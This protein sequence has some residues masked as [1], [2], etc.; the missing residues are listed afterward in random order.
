MKSSSQISL[1]VGLL[2][3]LGAVPLF[4]GGQPLFAGAVIIVGALVIWRVHRSLS[5]LDQISAAVAQLAVGDLS[6]PR[7]TI[8][9]TDDLEKLATSVNSL[10]YLLRG[11]SEE[12]VE[13]ADG[14]IGAKSM[15]QRV[16]ETGDLSQVDLPL[17]T[18]HGDLNHSFTLLTN[19][20][21]RVTVKALLIADDQVYNTA[22]D[23]KLPGEL[24]DAFGLMVRNLRGLA[25]RAADIADGDLKIQIDGDGDLTNAFNNMVVGL[26]TLVDQI[27]GTAVQLASSSEQILQVL[28]EQ[29]SSS[30]VQARKVQ[31]TQ[32]AMA[33][34]LESANAIASDAQGVATAA[35]Q[36]RDKNRQIGQHTD[37]LSQYIIR[38]NEILKQIRS[39]ADRSDLLALNASL[40]GS[41]AGS[42]GKGTALLAQEMRRL[43]ENTMTLVSDIQELTT[44]VRAAAHT[45]ADASQQGLKLSENTS[46]SAARIT[47][48]IRHQ[49]QETEAVNDAMQTLAGVTTQQV[50]ASRE[51]TAT[52]S[53][54][55]ELAE[56]LNR[57]VDRFEIDGR[58]SQPG[59]I[60][61]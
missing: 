19:Q 9:A 29:Q 54:L 18:K 38:I 15:V 46:E 22:L 43:A 42:S 53:E 50:N 4:L 36:T 52:A 47:E 39:I 44:G 7:L 61:N 2:A 8:N 40:E 17:N 57:L 41:R 31:R 14:M 32:Q 60:P 56:Q 58:S 20:L 27:V 3:L 34:L 25:S 21:R 5:S 48:F 55:A 59:E 37:K 24:G 49:N 11:F 6:Q 12:A 23:E 16:M 10:H 35:E 13:L 51:V 28:R 33:S 45:A 26:R 1:G 30:A